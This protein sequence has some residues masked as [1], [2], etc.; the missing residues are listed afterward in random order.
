MGLISKS[1]IATACVNAK[2]GANHRITLI[3]LGHIQTV[4]L[5]EL[6]NETAHRILTKH[7]IPKRSKATQ[8]RFY[9][10]HDRN[11][12][13]KFNM[14]WNPGSEN[15]AN[16]HVKYYPSSYHRRVISVYLVSNAFAP[17]NL[18]QVT[19]EAVSI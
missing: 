19:F 12:Q 16:N 1:E 10:S 17:P 18:F 14:R 15:H 7:L 11:N 9:W 4:T 8:M 13:N 6:D 2:I 3:E 5:L